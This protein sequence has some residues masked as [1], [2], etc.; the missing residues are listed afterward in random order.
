M[1]QK[2]FFRKK[3]SG[4][5][6]LELLVVISIIGLLIAMGV[7]AF[8]TA[9][10][11]GRDA[12]RQSDLKA[13]QNAQ[14]QYYSANGSVYATSCADLAEYLT[15]CPTDPQGGM[16]YSSSYTAAGYCVCAQLESTAG[17]AGQ[18]NCGDMGSGEYFC[19]RNLQ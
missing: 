17:N 16:Q 6:L 3:Q 7:A 4:F 10:R 18:S 11:K 9:Q 19:V 2:T 15:S 13:I 5:T 14:E 12:R 8:S 1:K